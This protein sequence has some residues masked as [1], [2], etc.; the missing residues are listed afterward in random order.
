MTAPATARDFCVRGR[1]RYAAG[2]LA[3]AVADF[4]Q[5][6]QADPRC[7]DAYNN[8]GAVRHAR[9]DLAAAIAD[10][11][12]ALPL[13][14]QPDAATLY[15]DRGASRL[16]QGDLGGARADFEIA[17][18]IDPHS[19][20][21]YISRG[22]ARYHQRDPDAVLDYRK[23]FRLDPWLAAQAIV[24]ILA[25]DLQRDPAH[26]F[27]NCASHLRQ[28]PD[29]VSAY[30]RRGLSYLLLGQEA[31]AAKDFEQ[32]LARPS[33]TAQQNLALLVRAVRLRRGH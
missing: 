4:D 28:N 2:D 13:T 19:C 25:D 3:G 33:P 26:V 9:G 27:A 32:F 10:F 31:E 30:C 20:V 15:H 14:L 6:L 22:N 8:R 29:D 5:A 12:A 24:R 7:V 16:A 21:A 23:A 11:D 1:Q 17:L 18:Q